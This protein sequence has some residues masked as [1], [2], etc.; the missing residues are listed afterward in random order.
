MAIRHEQ[1]NNDFPKNPEYCFLP[2]AVKMR[3]SLKMDVKV[4]IEEKTFSQSL[5]QHEPRIVSRKNSE[6]IL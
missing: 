4:D 5:P 6:K 2:K 1:E 3:S